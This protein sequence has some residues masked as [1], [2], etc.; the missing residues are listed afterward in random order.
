M[1]LFL[2][3][4]WVLVAVIAAATWHSHARRLVKRERRRG[5]IALSCVLVLLFFVISMTDDL[6][7]EVMLIEDSSFSRRH[8]CKTT[9][10]QHHP[11]SVLGHHH[12]APAQI[13]HSKVNA[14]L[15]LFVSAVPL[16]A[17]PEESR[18]SFSPLASRAPPTASR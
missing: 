12:A 16:F 10:H 17:A 8:V 7:A 18:I 14:P 3:L 5:W 4:F 13:G 11:D 15:Q 9:C 2:N 6:H 1:E